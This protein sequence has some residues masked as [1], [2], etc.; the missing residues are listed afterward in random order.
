MK[1][2]IDTNVIVSGLLSSYGNSAQILQL[3]ISGKIDICYDTRI[4]VEYYEVLNRP[5]FKFNKEYISILI[6]EIKLI[7]RPSPCSPLIQSLPDPDDDM[8]LEVA[9]ACTADCII[10]GNMNHFSKKLCVGVKVFTPAAFISYFREI[11]TY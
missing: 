6:K 2:V 5:K 11:G 7:G 4:L 3:L 8:F 9:L 1:V 10:T